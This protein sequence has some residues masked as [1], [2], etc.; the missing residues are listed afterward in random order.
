M[1][2][3]YLKL[4][5]EQLK[6]YPKNN[7]IHTDYDI[8]Q[9]M[10]SIQKSEYLSPIIID[11]NFV[12]INGHWRKEALKRLD[13]KEVDVLQITGLT[14][15]QKQTARLLDN[16]TVTLSQF[17]IENIKLELSDIW[18]EELNDLF[19]DLI[20]VDVD[21]DEIYKWMPEYD[22]QDLSAEY[23]IRVSFKELKD[24][25]A[26]GKLIGQNV[27]EKTRSIWFPATVKEDLVPK[28]IDE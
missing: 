10:K 26:F 7:K 15:K 5:I 21:Y 19:S 20:V 9:I 28:V 8:E 13:Y 23:Q 14:E 6:D 24:L 16:K 25:E 17:D 22:Q 4:P 1:Q 11:E 2:K 3:K 27:T 12:I 18:D